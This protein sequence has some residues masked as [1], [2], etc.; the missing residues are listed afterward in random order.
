[1]STEDQEE[2]DVT[3]MAD[4]CHEAGRCKQLSCGHHVPELMTETLIKALHV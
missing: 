3:V 2:T 4:I 1:M